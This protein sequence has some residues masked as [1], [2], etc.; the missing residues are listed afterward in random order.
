M[1]TILI[2][3]SRS[4]RYAQT[5]AGGLND[6]LGVA[7]IHRFCVHEYRELYVAIRLMQ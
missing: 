1:L 7:G 4:Q 5:S 3:L 2:V 6:H